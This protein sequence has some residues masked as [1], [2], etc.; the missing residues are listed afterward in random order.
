MHFPLAQQPEGQAYLLARAAAPD[1]TQV[2]RDLGALGERLDPESLREVMG[3]SR[4]E[5]GCLSFHIFRS[6]RDR[7][8]FYIHSHWVNADEFQKHATLPHGAVPRACGCT[9]GSAARCDANRDDRLN[10]RSR[11]YFEQ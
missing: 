11:K 2:A 7:R 3:H 4:E 8:L 10:S 9:A 6:M 5:S 1:A